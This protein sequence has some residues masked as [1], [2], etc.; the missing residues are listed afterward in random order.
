MGLTL[1]VSLLLRDGPVTFCAPYLTHDE[2]FA[3]CRANPDL[4]IERD[5]EG[6]VRFMSPAGSVTG[7]RNSETGRQLGNWNVPQGDIGFTFDSSTG[8][9]LP[10]GAERSPDASWVARER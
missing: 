6:Y 5:K 9:T 4:R 2:F 7:M 1:D 10:N 3:F 8:F